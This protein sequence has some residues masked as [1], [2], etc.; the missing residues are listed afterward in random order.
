MQLS[1]K[2]TCKKHT[3]IDYESDEFLRPKF[4]DFISIEYS[5]YTYNFFAYVVPIYYSG[6]EPEYN[7][8]I[9][10]MIALCNT[11]KLSKL[12]KKIKS[13]SAKI[14]VLDK[15]NR[16]IMSNLEV[17][18]DIKQKGIN[19]R[20]DDEKKYISITR[21]IED[22][23]CKI[24]CKMPI[25]VIQDDMVS[26]VNSLVLTTVVMV[27]LLVLIGIIINIVITS[28]VA[29]IVKAMRLVGEKNLTQRINMKFDGEIGYI[30]QNI[31]KMLDRIEQMTRRI[32]STQ[33]RLYE[34]EILKKQAELSALQSQ[35]NPH[36]LYNTLECIRSIGIAYDVNEVVEISTAMADIFRYSV[37]GG[38][39]VTVGDEIK[40]INK[41]F[42]IISIRFSGRF[43]LVTDVDEGIM[44]YRLPRMV[45]QPI[46][47]NAVYHGLEKKEGDGAISLKGTECNGRIIFIIQDDGVGIVPDEL[48]RLNNFI[49]KESS[50]ESK[51]EG[52]RS[53]GLLNI[54]ARIKMVFGNDYGIKINSPPNTGT[55][56]TV[57][58]PVI[59]Q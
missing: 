10:T 49:N 6:E 17:L 32:F 34:V 55:K 47:E 41:Y 23:D 43:T 53:V 4:T 37:K 28:P 50:E 52:K 42:S 51:D 8:R 3:N 31:N 45:L 21:P 40:T 26:F 2:S 46:I 11:E 38:D 24:E 54:N 25:T 35:I 5:R 15:Q 7:G 22:I 27:M 20:I 12:I 16:V 9:G 59:L 19:E 14:D 39:F 13:N 30:S 18:P 57:T 36:F 44:R 56:V 29:E 1:P 58:F 48:D 33:E